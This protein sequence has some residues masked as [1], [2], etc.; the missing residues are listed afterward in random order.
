[1]QTDRRIPARSELDGLGV[2]APG[3]P[4]EEVQRE[5]GLDRIIKLA[6]NENPFKSSSVV[7]DAVAAEME[8]VALYPEST[9]P[10]LAEKLGKHWGVEPERVFVGNGSDEIIGL[11]TR[12]YVRPLDEVVMADPTF[13]RYET[14][15]CI[16]GESRSRFRFKMACTTWMP[17]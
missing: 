6:S 8:R 16:E 14:N 11:L 2:Y 15:V 13:S 10:A 5:L 4:I 1:M 7:Y 3:K 12:A 17:C 9:A